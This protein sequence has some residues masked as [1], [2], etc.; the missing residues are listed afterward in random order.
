MAC[1][2]VLLDA[3]DYYHSGSMRRGLNRPWSRTVKGIDLAR[4]LSCSDILCHLHICFN[5][6]SCSSLCPLLLLPSLLSSGP[7][8]ARPIPCVSIT[9]KHRRLS[10]TSP[11]SRWLTVSYRC[12]DN[13]V[14]REIYIPEPPLT[15][16]TRKPFS[17]PRTGP[18]SP[19]APNTSLTVRSSVQ[20]RTCPP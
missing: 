10:T 20:L 8:S 15:P 11:P 1:D 12:G 2:A 19:A 18:S 5:L 7:S 6:S 17:K 16:K 9:C 14:S 3:E 13:T 4:H